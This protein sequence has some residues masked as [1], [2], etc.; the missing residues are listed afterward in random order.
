MP[1]G[2]PNLTIP[3]GDSKRAAGRGPRGGL[4]AHYPPW[5][6][7]TAGAGRCRVRLG[8]LTI[9]HGDSKHRTGLSFAQADRL[10]IPHGDSKPQSWPLRGGHGQRPHYPPWGFK[11]RRPA[12]HLAHALRQLTIPHGDSKHGTIWAKEWPVT[13]AHY[14]PWGFK[15]IPQNDNPFPVDDL[16]LSPMGIQNHY[17]SLPDRRFSCCSLSPMGIQND[18]TQLGLG[19]PEGSLSPMGIQNAVR[20]ARLQRDL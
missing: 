19:R 13:E 11:T 20:T 6:F 2:T 5:G 1:A 12:Y 3:H 18:G 14:P 16:S 15:T 9:P 7:K 4:P 17:S 8:D 10:T